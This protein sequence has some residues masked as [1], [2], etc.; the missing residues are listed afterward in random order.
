MFASA[1]SDERKY[2]G[3]LL[4]QKYVQILP[5]SL[6]GAIL[7][8]NFLRCLVN[9]LASSARYLHRIAERSLRT[10]HSCIDKDPQISVIFIRIL[11]ANGYLNFDHLTKTKTIE[12]ILNQVSVFALQDIIS[13]FGQLILRPN[14]Q[15][16][17][18]A[19]TTRQLVAD[20]LVSVV[21]S[22]PSPVEGDPTLAAYHGCI[23]S[24]TT[25]FL[26][27][28][29]FEVIPSV[30]DPAQLPE[31]PISIN[32][33]EVFKSRLTSCLSH[34]IIKS[35]NAAYHPFEVMSTI[36]LYETKN[37]EY[38]SLASFDV[39][40]NVPET[41]RSGW[42][43]IS[44]LNKNEQSAEAPRKGFLRAFKLLYTLNLLQI[45]NGDADA[46]SMIQEMQVYSGAILDPQS[47][48]D[49]GE[50]SEA[51][52][53]IILSLVSK[54]SLLFKRLAQQVF[55]VC[56]SIVNHNGLQSMIH[57]SVA[58]PYSRDTSNNFRY[59]RQRKASLGSRRSSSRKV[60]TAT[61][62]T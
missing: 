20:Y 37:K 23:S 32:T 31:P 51:L 48:L 1:S 10:I 17:K 43:T 58:F 40:S 25:I 49:Q 50:A 59:S 30:V 52:V 54:S 14:A 36:R 34:L 24:A 11:A 2:W 61:T 8:P 46:V 56:T 5:V 33:R 44:K 18:R 7:G 47:R 12:K 27:H 22:I 3:F 6:I 41:I 42:K 60:P 13:I 62:P 28:A 39:E 9:Q 4:F 29:Y 15:D 53:E 45:Y 35:D 57:V 38:K 55:S 19:S 26:K 21:R 16:E